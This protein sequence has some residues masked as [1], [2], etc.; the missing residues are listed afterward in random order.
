MRNGALQRDMKAKNKEQI[1]KERKLPVRRVFGRV[2][3]VE[4]PGRSRVVQFELTKSGLS[5]RE[6]GTR[7]ASAT[8]LGFPS[9][10]AAAG[11]EEQVDGERLRFALVDGGVEVRNGKRSRVVSYRAVARLGQEQPWLF[12]VPAAAGGRP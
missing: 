1:I 8:L 3:G 5:F 4:V 7:K 6:R 2:R 12:D 10:A 9:L 11:R